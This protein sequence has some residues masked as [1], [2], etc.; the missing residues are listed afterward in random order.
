MDT[1]INRGIPD[2]I[3]LNDKQNTMATTTIKLDKNTR[4]RLDKL[5][6]HPKESFDD[7]LKRM[8][9]ILSI[10]RMAPERARSRLL[11][12]ERQKK[13]FMPRKSVSKKQA[14]KKGAEEMKQ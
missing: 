3:R 10:V 4:E 13:I 8:L 14:P 9:D 2:S 5:R 6:V 11:L 12:I 7:I 1:S